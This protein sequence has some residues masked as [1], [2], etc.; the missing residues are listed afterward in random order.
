VPSSVAEAESADI[1]V[2]GAG[3]AGLAAARRLAE[4]GRSVLLIEARDRVGGR[5]WTMEDSVEMGAEFVHGR[6][7]ATLA[8]LGEA[9]SGVAETVGSRAVLEDG[10]L[11]RIDYR[12]IEGRDQLMELA[13]RAGPDSTVSNFLARAVAEHP[14]L[15]DAAEWVCRMAENYDAADPRRA[16]LHALV[17]EW[18][19]MSTGGSSGGRPRGGYASLTDHMLRALDESRVELRLGS[20]VRAVRWR[21]GRVELEV[22][23]RGA[24]EKLRARAAIVTLPLGVLQAALDDPAAVRFDPPLERKRAA[25][26][27][28]G[29]GAVLKVMLRFRERF[30][31]RVD[32]GRWRDTSFFHAAELPFRTFWAAL[33]ER[34]EWLTAWVGGPGAAALAAL[35]DEEIVA[36]AV[37]SVQKLFGAGVD[38]RELLVET[39]FHNWERDARSRGAYSYVLAGGASA[40]RALAEPLD[41]TLYFAGEAADTSGEA[42]TVA[43]AIVSGERAARESGVRF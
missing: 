24:L 30:W 41:D 15:S 36:T 23:R 28:L 43:G 7:E 37:E 34:S 10:R 6:P 25:L 40:R 29:M 26:E 19:G 16:S 31:E 11:E 27:G 13:E 39:R 38:V 12:A 4:A 8:L 9:G 32:D 5:I 35:A 20:T 17:E 21:P 33:P 3:A 22:E 18:A 14:E 1:A 42:T 2:I